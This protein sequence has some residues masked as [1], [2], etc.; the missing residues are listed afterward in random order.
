MTNK[1]GG[2]L[3]NVV[4]AESLA[5]GLSKGHRSESV[6]ECAALDTTSSDSAAGVSGEGALMRKKVMHTARKS[7]RTPRLIQKSLLNTQCRPFSKEIDRETELGWSVTMNDI[8]D[9]GVSTK[10]GAI[11]DPMS[12]NK[13]PWTNGKEAAFFGPKKRVSKK[14]LMNKRRV[15]VK[16]PTS[17]FALDDKEDSVLEDDEIFKAL[18]A[19]ETKFEYGPQTADSRSKVKLICTRFESICRAIVQ[20]AGHRSM[21]VRRID[22]AADKL[23]R[24]LPG[25]TK[26]GPVVGSVPGVE[27][28]D[29]FLYRVQLALVG[30]HRPFQGGIDSTSHETGVRIAISVVA[31]GGY[32]DEL[33]SRSGELVYTGSGK[34]DN[35]DQK[36]EH[37]NLA[38]KNCIGMKTPVRVIHG[39]KDQNREEGSHSRAREIS[40]FTYDGLYHVV[41]CW[42]EGSPGSKVFKYKLQRIPGQPQLSL[43]MAKAVVKNSMR[44]GFIFTCMYANIIFLF[45]FLQFSVLFSCGNYI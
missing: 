21:K 37:G 17:A 34:K 16:G 14:K 22:L 45:A 1:P 27:V 40:T 30:L 24:K 18:A 44:P 2:S 8:E 32:P 19:H 10:D 5:Q 7:V 9:T 41:D 23:I 11:Q 33:L 4:A 26:Q 15:T 13:S 35:G 31:S 12:A 3:C 29:E 42:R 28:G 39:F 43:H 25:F 20:A 6:S 38:L 36:L